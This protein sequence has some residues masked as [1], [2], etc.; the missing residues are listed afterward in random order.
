MEREQSDTED[1]RMPINLVYLG[2]HDSIKSISFKLERQAS[3]WNI[4]QLADLVDI[5]EH[6]VSK[7]PVILLSDA[8]LLQESDL[9]EIRIL[10][11]AWSNL[12]SFTFV[13]RANLSS[14]N[15]LSVCFHGICTIDSSITELIQGL[16]HVLKN[17]IYV[18]HHIRREILQTYLNLQGQPYKQK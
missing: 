17:E 14:I 2:E 7:T 11:S 8:D 4:V 15:L 3:A 13:S 1:R 12:K 9:N 18:H 6:L 10:M 16:N 5:H